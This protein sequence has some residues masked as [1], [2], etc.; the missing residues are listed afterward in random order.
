M[1]D[2][3]FPPVTFHP[4]LLLSHRTTLSP[5]SLCSSTGIRPHLNSSSI[6]MF[7]LW[8]THFMDVWCLLWGKALLCLFMCRTVKTCSVEDHFGNGSIVPAFIFIC[9][10][11]LY[12]A[13]YIL[14]LYTCIDAPLP[15]SSISTS[16]PICFFQSW[17]GWVLL[18][19]QQ[20]VWNPWRSC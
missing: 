5:V 8:R 16:L 15:S 6:F 4:S 17:V 20:H 13:N 14:P 2:Q 12:W 19:C 9:Q 7:S 10:V 18:G 3:P 11:W 1:W